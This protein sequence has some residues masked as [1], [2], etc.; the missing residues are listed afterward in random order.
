MVIFSCVGNNHY[1][2]YCKKMLPFSHSFDKGSVLYS[3]VFIE[4]CTNQQNVCDDFRVFGKISMDTNMFREFS[5][6]KNHP[7][8]LLETMDG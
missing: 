7:L 1:G 4:F 5:P 8:S 3:F 2:D 6:K